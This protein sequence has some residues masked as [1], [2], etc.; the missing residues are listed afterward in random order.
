MKVD[1]FVEDGFQWK[2]TIFFWQINSL[3]VVLSLLGFS[4]LHQKR[5][6]TTHGQARKKLQACKCSLQTIFENIVEIMG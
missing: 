2:A 6:V 1:I 5:L 3:W 4:L